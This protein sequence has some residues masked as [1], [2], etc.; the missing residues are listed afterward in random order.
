MDDGWTPDVSVLANAAAMTWLREVARAAPEPDLRSAAQALLDALSRA[1]SANAPLP[2][3]W[4]GDRDEVSAWHLDAVIRFIE[5]HVDPSG[6]F[7]LTRNEIKRC[8]YFVNRLKESRRR[9]ARARREGETWN[10]K[11]QDGR[12]SKCSH[13]R[14]RPWE[15]CPQCTEEA[16]RQKKNPPL[17]DPPGS[18]IWKFELPIED[19]PTISMPTK[20]HAL[21]V[22][23]QGGAL[24]LWAYVPEPD[25]TKESRH[26]FVVGTGNPIPWDLTA[27]TFI[28]TVQ[29]GSFVWHVFDQRGTARESGTR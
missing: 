1:P 23:V 13:G 11:E 4:H 20:A 2:K 17:A 3:A 18:R 15:G 8:T 28:G 26:F 16:A 5:R 19:E 27:S 14:W 21:S 10:K 6:H 12:V 25:A 29:I 9:V 24:V 22:G 7:H